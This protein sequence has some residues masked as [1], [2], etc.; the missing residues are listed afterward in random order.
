MR[1]FLPYLFILAW[2]GSSPVPAFSDGDYKYL[3]ENG[4]DVIFSMPDTV[5]TLSNPG[6]WIQEA[7]QHI[8]KVEFHNRSDGLENIRIITFIIPHPMEDKSKGLIDK[9]YILDKDGLIIGYHVFSP[10]DKKAVFRTKINGVINY[11]KVYIFCS[12]HGAWMTELK[13]PFRS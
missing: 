4:N 1:S 7:N 3:D 2:L 12:K 10:S 13:L 8:P 11:A 6:P 5:Y 9:I